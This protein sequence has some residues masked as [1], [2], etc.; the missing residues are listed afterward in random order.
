MKVNI[1]IPLVC[2]YNWASIM[3]FQFGN[4]TTWFSG[5]VMI[6]IFFFSHDSLLVQLGNESLLQKNPTPLAFHNVLKDKCFLQVPI[7]TCHMQSFSHPLHSYCS[8]QVSVQES[9]AHCWRPLGPHKDWEARL[10]H[11]L[12]AKNGPQPIWTSSLRDRP[13]IFWIWVCLRRLQGCGVWK[14]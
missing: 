3:K 7:Q 14:L 2:W 9:W 6:V 1:H 8:K 13:N 10:L 11:P 5:N 4:W 12:Q